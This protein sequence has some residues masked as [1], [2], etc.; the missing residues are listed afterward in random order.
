MKWLGDFYDLLVMSRSSMWI[1]IFH[2]ILNR[3]G[4]AKI[5]CDANYCNVS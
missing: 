1:W 3:G 5:S 2:S 4:Q